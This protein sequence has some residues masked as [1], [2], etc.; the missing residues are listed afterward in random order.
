MYPEQVGLSKR[1]VA[2]KIEAG[3]ATLT[4]TYS[5]GSYGRTRGALLISSR[6]GAKRA[7]AG[8]IYAFEQRKGQGQGLKPAPVN[9]VKGLVALHR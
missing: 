1:S 9:S 3:D 7:S 6:V 8:R 4:P 2:G 5:L